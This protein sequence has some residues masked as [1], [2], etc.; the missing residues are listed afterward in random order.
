VINIL[1]QD[2]QNP[3]ETPLLKKVFRKAK[4]T[5]WTIFD[6]EKIDEIIFRT[7][8]PRNRI[9][10]ELMARAGMRISEVLGLRPCDV[11]GR[12]LILRLPKSGKTK[13][14]VYIPQK[15]SNRLRQYI[16]DKNIQSEERVFP[17]SYP[18]ARIMVNKS[19]KVVGVK[20]RPHDLRRFAA[21]YASRCGTPI[22]IVSKIILRHASLSTTQR[23][24][25][26]VSDDEAMRWVES[27]YK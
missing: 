3:C 9:M 16:R 22:E 25:G 21:T 19:G 12:K 23:Y 6:K 11:E 8:N 24:L 4:P 18:T 26:K 20:L 27:L 10:L 17:I 7:L 1:D 5:Q 14:V 2:F 15:L 13:E